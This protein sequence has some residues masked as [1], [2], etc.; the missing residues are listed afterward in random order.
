MFTE[1]K[2]EDIMQTYQHAVKLKLDQE[3]IEILKK[4]MV[5][6]GIMIEEN[7]KKK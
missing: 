1:L 3:F 7:L 5:Q 4:E 2:N 6:R